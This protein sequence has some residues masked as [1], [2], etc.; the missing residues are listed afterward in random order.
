MPATRV[1][2]VGG[3]RTVPEPDPIARDYVL[4]GLRLDQHV[5]GLVDG[6]FG[7]AALK[8]QVDLESQRA[9]DRLREDA[10]EL[11]ERVRGEPPGARRAWLTAQLTALERQAAALAGEELSYLE[12]VTRCFGWTPVRRDEAVFEAAAARIDAMLPGPGP[13]AERLAA[14]DASLE[15]PIERLPGLIDWLVA[16]LRGRAAALFGLPEGE[17]LRVSLVRDQPWSG[18]NW[19]DGGLHSRVDINTDLPVRVPDLLRTLAH[20]TYPGHHL[21]HAWKEADLVERQGRLESSVLLINTP[22]C[23]ISEGL[24]DL[25]RDFALPPDGLVDLLVEV[26]ARAGLDLAADSGRARETADRAAGLAAPRFELNAVRVNAALLR[27]ADGASHEVTRDYLV[28]V[29]RYAPEVAAKRLEFIE[30]PLWRTYVFVYS[31][32]EALLR[33]WLEVVPAADRPARF[34]R[35]LH[36]QVTPGS[37]VAELNERI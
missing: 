2:A 5:P 21:E 4:L 19:Y 30:H 9:P 16:I 34:A 29:G 12:H 13:L 27:H 8:A 14:F 7:P 18:Y 23:L 33:R 11:L 20:E 1:P 28:R 6:Y 15:I 37:I 26:F 3:T 10:A 31:E 32:G 35:L 36:E 25:G 22:E 17:D 24:A